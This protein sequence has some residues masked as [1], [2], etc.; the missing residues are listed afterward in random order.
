MKKQ[1]ALIFILGLVWLV[2]GC[3]PKRVAPISAEDNPAH[4]YLMGM[5]LIDKGDLNEASTRFERAVKLEPDYAPALAGKALV[6]ALRTSAEKDKEH[7]SVELKRALDLL[8]DADDEAEG[9]SQKFAVRVTGIRV[10]MNAKP[11]KWIDEAEKQYKRAMR[12]SKVK[13]TELPPC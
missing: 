3:A 5:E 8:D 7:Q 11:K 9:D 13:T 12:L 6:A 1:M 2:G 10:F 4:H